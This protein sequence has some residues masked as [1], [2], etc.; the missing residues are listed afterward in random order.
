MSF[1]TLFSTGLA[2]DWVAPDG[3]GVL[4]TYGWCLSSDVA[5]VGCFYKNLPVVG[6]SVL[7]RSSTVQLEELTLY[8]GG[9]PLAVL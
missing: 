8:Q 1:R 4:E 2:R 6:K 5:A 7:R 9:R 3:A